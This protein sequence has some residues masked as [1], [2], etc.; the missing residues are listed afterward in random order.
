MSTGA[1]SAADNM[2]RL[3]YLE[4]VRKDDYKLWEKDPQL[5]R[6]PP[7]STNTIDEFT[8][9]VIQE[10]FDIS[11]LSVNLASWEERLPSLQRPL[12]TFA[13]TKSMVEDSP[14]RRFE[15]DLDGLTW[16][17]EVFVK[18]WE[19]R[20]GYLMK[21]LVIHLPNDGFFYVN[22][23][24]VSNIV[25]EIKKDGQKNNRH[26]NTCYEGWTVLE[27]TIWDRLKPFETFM[28]KWCGEEY[29]QDRLEKTALY[30]SAAN[31]VDICMRM[32]HIGVEFSFKHSFPVALEDDFWDSIES[33]SLLSATN[34]AVATGV[35][36]TPL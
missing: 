2:I 20:S 8:A 11:H 18:T 27:K 15:Y 23:A 29:D 30:H 28:A 32:D 22:E 36:P 33:F 16:S 13:E 17:S 7:F 6:Q 12:F 3:L 10:R 9:E 1:G 19:S 21:T 26:K 34:F 24:A 31:R 4:I 25:G 5:C 35:T 14:K